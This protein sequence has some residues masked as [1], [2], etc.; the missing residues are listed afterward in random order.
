LQLRVRIEFHAVRERISEHTGLM[1]GRKT[2]ARFLHPAILS[3][4]AD[5]DQRD[6]GA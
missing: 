4:P 2:R 1:K 6:G 5:H 3:A